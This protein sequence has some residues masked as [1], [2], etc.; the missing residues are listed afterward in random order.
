MFFKINSISLVGTLNWLLILFP[1]SFVA[2]NTI[3][4]LNL[5]TFII[6]G[7]FYLTKIKINIKYNLLFI[8]QTLLILFTITLI[9]SSYVNNFNIIKSILF[10]RFPIFIFICIYLFKEKSFN[11]EKIFY[12][13]AIFVSVIV[14]DL[15]FQYLLGFNIIG[16]KQI[17]TGP[18]DSMYLAST[19]FFHGEKIAGSFVQNFGFF[20]VF[21]IFKIFKKND[22][23]A[24]FYQSI[25]ISLISIS[26][27]ASDQRM[28]LFIWVFFLLI[29]GLFYF[30]T[31]LLPILFSIILL[32]LF[33]FNFSSEDSIIRYSSFID[34]A[35]T[36]GIDSAKNLN[37]INDKEKFNEVE[38]DK[39]KRLDYVKGSG[40]ATLYA[41]ALYIWQENKIIGT[42]YKNFY[43]KC[44]EKK[45]LRCATHPHNYYLDILV[46]TGIVGFFIIFLFVFLLFFKTIN[47][48]L[49]YINNKNFNKIDA[50]S[51]VFI[52]FLMFFFPL[53]SSGSF[54]TTSNST[55]MIVV[56]AMLLS[57]LQKKN[58]KI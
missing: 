48:L 41:S 13:Y 46:S 58:S 31:K 54:F 12:Y 2:G 8:S 22:F 51:I 5:F 44:A 1:L 45:L 52:N 23:K 50:L 40:H 30:K 14:L 56:L 18:G 55:Y 57:L 49:I 27:F 29:Y 47:F 53:K 39:E 43:I 37:L 9:F 21:V 34:N 28:S 24:F 4:N 26:I 7:L 38:G 25:F 35:K 16:L 33:I 20:L 19:S 17:E 36:I 11:L 42:G 10:L 6:L 15:I 3:L 32:N